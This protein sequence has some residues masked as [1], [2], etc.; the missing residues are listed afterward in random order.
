MIEPHLEHLRACCLCLQKN[1]DDFLD[2]TR[3]LV[4][5]ARFLGPVDLLQVALEHF[6]DNDRMSTTQRWPVDVTRVKQTRIKKRFAHR[7][8]RTAVKNRRSFIETKL[9]TKIKRET[10]KI[11]YKP[12]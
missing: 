9:Q 10:I 4:P 5:N 7:L 2:A 6:N 8:A 1:A 3:P 12:L 11:K